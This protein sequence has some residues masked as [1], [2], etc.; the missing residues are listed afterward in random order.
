MDP[1]YVNYDKRKNA[2]SNSVVPTPTANTMPVFGAPAANT[3]TPTAPTPTA[4]VPAA[5][6]APAAPAPAPIAPAAPT[7]TPSLEPAPAASPANALVAELDAPVVEQ[8]PFASFQNNTPAAEPQPEQQFAPAEQPLQTQPIGP[9]SISSGTGDIVLDMSQPKGGINKK[10]LAIIGG[11][12]LVVI[13]AVVAVIFLIP[14]DRATKEDAEELYSLLGWVSLTEQCPAV[15]D[16]VNDLD[17]STEKYLEIANSCREK[18]KSIS[19]MVSKLEK[20]NDAGFKRVIDSIKSDMSEVVAVGDELESELQIFESLHEW[21]IKMDKKS[22]MQL[23]DD[24]IREISS[25]LT[26]SS[27]EGLRGFGEK[28]T[29]KKI[30]V[31][32]TELDIELFG[33]N[34]ILAKKLAKAT[35]ELSKIMDEDLPSLIEG[36]KIGQIHKSPALYGDLLE[37]DNYL[38]ENYEK[39]F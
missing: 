32:N 15:T 14:K 27:N 37:Y 23:A 33:E 19:T 31:S 39:V 26:E 25:S 1:L 20:I 4:P 38:R 8:N 11:V 21:Y 12:V 35:S 18:G 36:T 3:S 13:A 7:I 6:V 30:A 24:D 2:T 5:P 17:Y 28:W 16:N 9:A 29:E 34:D 22:G 10:L